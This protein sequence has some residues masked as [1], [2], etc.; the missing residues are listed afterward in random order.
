[1][2]PRTRAQRKRAREEEDESRCRLCLEGEA[3]GPLVQL[4]ACRGSAKLVHRRC[5]EKWRR[6]SPKEDAAYRCG[7]CKDEYRDALSLELLSARLQAERVDGQSTVLIL[8]RLALELQA[9][10]KYGEAEP[11]YREALEAQRATLGSRHPHTLVS[12]GNF[13]SLLK[14]KGD[15]AAAEPL[16]REALEV[17]RET[18][19]SRHPQTLT[20]INNLGKLLKEKGDQP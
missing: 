14:D 3:D 7:E 4:C 5:L 1:M 6:T 9:Q 15:L 13:G 11:L 17:R 18:L 16:Y 12:I 8:N 20:S 2:A 19:G 10:G